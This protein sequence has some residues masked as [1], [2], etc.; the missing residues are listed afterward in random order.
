MSEELK[1]A[2][3]GLYQPP[4]RFQHG[5]I[6][7]SAGNM[8]A[9]QGPLTETENMLALQVRGWGRIQYI[10]EHNPAELQ[11]AVGEI[12]AKALTEYWANLNEKS[13]D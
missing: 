10:K 3:L 13:T 11:D 5:Y 9:D 12:I 4:F 8:F 7:D 2:A 1:K 6:F